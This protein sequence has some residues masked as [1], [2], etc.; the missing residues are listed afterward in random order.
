M[1]D[2]TT[3]DK[4]IL[5]WLFQMWGGFVLDFSDRTMGDFFK[6]DI[7]ININAEKYNY[8]SWS[9]ANRMR[10]FWAEEDNAIVGG[11]ILKLIGYIESK[12]ILGDFKQTTF[13]DIKLKA[14]QKIWNRLLDKKNKESKIETEVDLSEEIGKYLKKSEDEIDRKDYDWA[15]GTLWTFLEEFFEDLHIR[16]TWKSIWKNADIKQ[17]YAKIKKLLNLAPDLYIDD[18][19]KQMLAW[20]S[21]IIDAI[22][23]LC[24]TLWDR[25]KKLKDEDMNTKMRPL[26][27]HALLMLNSAKTLTLFLYDSYKYQTERKEY[28]EKELLNILESDSNKGELIKAD[29]ARNKL[30]NR[31]FENIQ[32]NK[33][34]KKRLTQSDGF[35]KQYII[36]KYI[37]QYNID[38]R[39]KNSKFFGLMAVLYDN[40]TTEDVVKIYNKYAISKNDQAIYLWAF[41]K[42]LVEN[43]IS[44]V[45]KDI[46]KEVSVLN[47]TKYFTFISLFEVLIHQFSRKYNNEYLSEEAK[48]LKKAVKWKEKELVGIIKKYFNNTDYTKQ[49]IDFINQEDVNNFPLPDSIYT[50][51]DIINIKQNFPGEI[52]VNIWG[53]NIKLSSKW[54]EKIQKLYGN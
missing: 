2:L 6:D 22:D 32:K 20:F 44:I 13:S 50:I 1:A 33:F 23:W 8:A 3:I 52:D 4:Q 24:N 36:K 10:G 53:K 12:I 30:S 39:D 47:S 43:K 7:G 49:I 37:E 11:S 31:S 25:H 16:L 41:I 42:Y 38:S 14:W 28:L 18:K 26:K 46:Q 54:V 51:N 45:P 9:K 29:K 19:I 48:E 5:E 17:D 35:I 27:H 40:L 34:V 21:Q 15:I